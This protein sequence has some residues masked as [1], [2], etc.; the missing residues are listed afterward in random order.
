MQFRSDSKPHGIFS[1]SSKGDENTFLGID[2]LSSTMT[3]VPSI[4]FMNELLIR[5]CSQEINPQLQA[6]AKSLTS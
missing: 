1:S 5:F 2:A 6:A 3:A 4:E